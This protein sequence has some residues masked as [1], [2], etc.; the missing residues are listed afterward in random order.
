[1]ITRGIVTFGE[2][3]VLHVQLSVSVVLVANSSRYCLPPVLRI[4]L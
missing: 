4:H 3:A 1:M 2:Y